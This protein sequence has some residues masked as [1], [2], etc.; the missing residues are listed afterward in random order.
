MFWQ[1]VSA[2][3]GSKSSDES[4]C[5]GKWFLPSVV[6]KVVMSPNDLAEVCAKCGSKSSDES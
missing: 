6:L 2:K 1:V 5:F 4:K 3:C